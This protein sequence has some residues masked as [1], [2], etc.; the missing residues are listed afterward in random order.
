VALA[1][2]ALLF[3]GTYIRYP[4]G[5]RSAIRIERLPEQ[6]TAARLSPAAEALAS[7][8]FELLN[9]PDGE[10]YARD[11]ALLSWFDASAAAPAPPQSVPPA[12]PESATPETSAPDTEQ[13]EGG[14]PGAP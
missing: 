1:V 12:L 5:T 4:I 8:D 7:P 11:L 9:D 2:L 3:V 14:R 13:T 6:P 10:R